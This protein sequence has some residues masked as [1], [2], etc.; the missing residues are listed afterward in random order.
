MPNRDGNK[1][2]DELMSDHSREQRPQHIGLQ[3]INAHGPVYSLPS[4]PP[5]VVSA[6]LESMRDALR[7]ASGG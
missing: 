5:E 1:V 3:I 7:K 4:P 6:V 2:W